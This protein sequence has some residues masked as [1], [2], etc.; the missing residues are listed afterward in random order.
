MLQRMTNRLTGNSFRL[1]AGA[2]AEQS[3]I[4]RL[5]KF[6]P[7]TISALYRKGR[8][9]WVTCTAKRQKRKSTI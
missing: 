4:L 2:S 5:G 8:W 9:L 7:E 3:A 1:P 6:G